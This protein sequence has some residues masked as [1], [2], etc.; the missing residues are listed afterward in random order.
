MPP[1]LRVILWQKNSRCGDGEKLYYHTKLAL[2]LRLADQHSTARSIIYMKAP[3]GVAP[4]M[5]HGAS[6]SSLLSACL[7]IYVILRPRVKHRLV[8]RLAERR[9]A[10]AGEVGY[11]A[12]L[13]ALIYV[14]RDR[15]PLELDVAFQSN[16]A[17]HHWADTFASLPDP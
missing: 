6:N 2:L 8:L 11:V 3:S 12:A 16:A 1:F 4:P 7:R 10:H 13:A 14:I 17:D 15:L 5:P 9:P